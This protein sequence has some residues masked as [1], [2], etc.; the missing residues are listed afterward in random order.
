M[1]YPPHKVGDKYADGDAWTYDKLAEIAKLLTVDEAGNNADSPAFDWE[2]TVQWGW[3]GWDWGHP[4]KWAAKWGGRPT[5]VSEDYKTAL[6]NSAGWVAA[7]EYDK[8]A[9][10]DLHIRATSEQAGAFYAAASDPMGSGMVAMWE[11]HSWMAW[12]YGSWTE[13]FNW[14]IG[15]I[16]V[17]PGHDPVGGMHADTFVMPNASEHKNEA[18]EVVKWMWKPE[19]LKRLCDNWG[20]M[21]AHVDLADTW[22]DDMAA[23]YPDVDFPVFVDAANYPDVPNHEAWKPRYDEMNTVM[24]SNYD[25]IATGENLNVQEVMDKMNSEAQALLNEYWESQ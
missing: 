21:P 3:N 23:K 1:D 19:N 24:N 17:V 14:D 5:G 13:A 11:C 22:V 25:L 16:P 18:W 7:I 15:A 6:F 2:N 8:A 10:W 12:A 4:G 20:A 9:R